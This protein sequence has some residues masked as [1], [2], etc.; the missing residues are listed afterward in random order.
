MLPIKK[1]PYRGNDYSV[2][3]RLRK[4]EALARA[5]KPELKSISFVVAGNMGALTGFANVDLTN[6]AEGTASNERIGDKI[7]LV[8]MEI[9]GLI[10]P[11][12]D[13]HAIKC[14]STT[15]PTAALFTGGVGTFLLESETG[16]RFRELFHYRSWQTIDGFLGNFALKRKL[17]YN[18]QYS[19]TLGTTAQL[20][21]TTIT[22]V[23]RSAA[24]KNYS[25]TVRL[26]YTDG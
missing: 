21:C 20:G 2:A 7:H 25:F 19:G 18:C 1:R 26:F 23:N 6:I 16:S 4:V 24:A 3:K 5:N 14:N 22:L 11:D 17:G 15:K 13:A 8:S 12:I 9:R 10:D